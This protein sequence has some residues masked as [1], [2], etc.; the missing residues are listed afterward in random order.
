MPWA[1]ASVQYVWCQADTSIL[2][3]MIMRHLSDS[4]RD[5]VMALS[6]YTD[7]ASG[8]CSHRSGTVRSSWRC[9]GEAPWHRD[10]SYAPAPGR[11]NT[12]AF[13]RDRRKWSPD[14]RKQLRR[15]KDKNR[16]QIKDGEIGSD[17][18]GYWFYTVN[19]LWGRSSLL[20]SRKPWHW[21]QCLQK[22]NNKKHKT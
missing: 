7:L 14:Q 21:I 4:Y 19:T 11:W 2:K 9:K 17:L 15:H 3:I 5:S 8:V 20:C 10:A 12:A 22:I 16:L 13:Q 1:S 6:C 18:K